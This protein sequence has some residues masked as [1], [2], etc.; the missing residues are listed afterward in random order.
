MRY[1][2]KD[3]ES[4]LGVLA[5]IAGV[6]LGGVASNHGELN[7][8]AWNYSSPTTYLGMA[9]G[10]LAGGA[11]ASGGF[12]LAG[13]VATPYVS[14]GV[15]VAGAGLGAGVGTGWKYDFH[16]ST[17]AGGGG[18]IRNYST[19]PTP[20]VDEAIE[21]A[22][23]NFRSFQ[24]ATTVSM[25]LVADDVTGLWVADN[26]LIAVAYGV[27]TA[28]FMYDNA[29]LIMKRDKEIEGIRNRIFKPNQGFTY[30]LV[31]T[32]DG[33]YTDVRKGRTYLHTGD[34]WKYGETTNYKNRY[35]NEM[36]RNNNLHMLELFRGNQM[37]IKIMEKYFIYGYVLVN[38]ELPPGNRIFR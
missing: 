18:G 16:W 35:N 13:T 34:V 28:G 2:D 31:A 36:Y 3:V 29:Q 14:A 20:A 27:A 19:D 4:F 26:V 38:R 8:F 33:Y 1:V 32:K 21:N 5:I 24:Y 10:G 37:T 6:Y 11:L 7:P 12:A 17:A 25:G 22:S 9:F 15:T 30:A 23:W